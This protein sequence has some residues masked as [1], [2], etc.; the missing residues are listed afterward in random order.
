MDSAEAADMDSKQPR[1]ECRQHLP[2]RTTDFPLL[3]LSYDVFDG[4]SSNE[5]VVAR[6]IGEIVRID[7][8]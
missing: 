4:A 5:N 3:R 1:C 7:L 2:R 8:L 6:G